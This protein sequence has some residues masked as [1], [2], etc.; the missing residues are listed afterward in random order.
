MKTPSLKTQKYVCLFL[1][2][3]YAAAAIAL[4]YECL[5]TT[6]GARVIVYSVTALMNT[7]WIIQYL[8]DLKAINQRIKSES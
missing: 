1:M 6:D 3:M 2:T 7:Y 4:I 5:F 8:K